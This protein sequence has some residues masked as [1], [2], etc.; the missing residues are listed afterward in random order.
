[1]EAMTMRIVETV[2][3][4]FALLLLPAAPAAAQEVDVDLELVLAV[5]VSRSMDQEEQALQ[6][7][8]YLAALQHPEVIAAIRSGFLG[9][10]AITYV[11]WAGPGRQQIIAPWTMVDG[12]GTAAALAG[13]I[14]AEPVSFLRGTSISSAL[15]YTSGLFAGNGFR[16]MRQVID[17]S[18]DG[19][20][21]MGI[22]VL[23]ARAAVLEQGITINGLP[24]VLNADYYGGYSIPDLDIYYEDCVIGGP[25]AFLVT[26]AEMSRF[27]EAVRRKLVLE[28]A[29]TAPQVAP[30]AFGVE[31][32]PRIDCLIGEKLRRRWMDP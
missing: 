26:V 15:T 1:M 16:G 17:I 10:V 18:G 2:F 30:A 24:I 20:N 25:G 8:G 22:P 23:D 27:A 19:P 29:G 5:D 11:E 14:A 9:R 32:E 12:E 13:A 6:K 4:S 3:A 21:N 31:R 28:I 7:E